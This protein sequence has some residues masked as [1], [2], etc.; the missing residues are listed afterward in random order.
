VSRNYIWFL[1]A[2]IFAIIPVIVFAVSAVTY[3]SGRLTQSW[4]VASRLTPSALNDSSVGGSTGESGQALPTPTQTPAR[5]APSA[6]MTQPA[7]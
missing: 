4:Q 5:G 2:I 7:D 1:F 3:P 6:S